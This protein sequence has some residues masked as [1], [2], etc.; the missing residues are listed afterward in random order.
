M[1]QNQ[2]TTRED[3]M[4]KNDVE[5]MDDELKENSA[6]E[7]NFTFNTFKNMLKANGHEYKSEY[8]ETDNYLI[9]E[10]DNY[11]Y[12]ILA[13]LLADNGNYCLPVTIYDGLDEKAPIQIKKDF[14]QQCLFKAID[15]LLA[16]ID[17]YN[18]TYSSKK[19]NAHTNIGLFDIDGVKQLYYH[20]VL[21]NLWDNKGKEPPTI[22]IFNDRM[23]LKFTY[24]AIQ[25]D[26]EA[27]LITI[28]SNYLLELFHR[29]GITPD[30]IDFNWL[31]YD[32]NLFKIPIKTTI[33]IVFNKQID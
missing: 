21:A 10:Y 13:L 15:E 31:E 32:D 11:K 30:K 20:A 8:F 33:P 3:I 19:D 1:D 22:E 6:N 4:L 9:A 24:Q 17:S 29:V 5:Y 27:S 25:S 23:E 28:Y 14:G 2:K 26:D 7:Q 16:F 18:K 12:N